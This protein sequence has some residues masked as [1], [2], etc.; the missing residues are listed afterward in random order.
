MIEACRQFLSAR[1]MEIK[2]RANAQPFDSENIFFGP[3]PRDFLKGH[4]FAACCLT[5]TDK[6]RFH[7]GIV[8]NQRNEDCTEYTRIRKSYERK[9]LYR[10]ILYA[11]Q[12]K[13][14]WGETDFKGFIDQLE[15]RIAHYRVIADALNMAVHIN[16]QDSIRPWDQESSDRMLKKRSHKAIARVEFTGGVYTQ[17]QVPIIQDVDIQ[18][19]Y[20]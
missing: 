16:L 6:K 2:D 18:P 5:L 19:E 9:V 17:K 1:L 4:R 11:A 8:L 20:E 7:G 10:I 15:Q 14:H 12:F 3:M 13:D